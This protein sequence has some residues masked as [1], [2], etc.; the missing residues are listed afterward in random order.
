MQAALEKAMQGTETGKKSLY[1]IDPIK[2]KQAQLKVILKSNPAEDDYHTWIRD[3]EDIVN[4]KENANTQLDLTKREARLAA[5]KAATGH[6][7]STDS[8]SAEIEEFALL[9][10]KLAAAD[11]ARNI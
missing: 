4:I 10:R 6:D 3:V 8:I 7:V 1:D 11:S 9:H 2:R 5:L